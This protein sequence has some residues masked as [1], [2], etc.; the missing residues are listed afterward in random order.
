MTSTALTA[1]RPR[2]RRCTSAVTTFA[3]ADDCAPASRS[4]RGGGRRPRSARR[5]W[6]ID[7]S[8]GSSRGRMPGPFCSTVT[9]IP[10]RV[11]RLRHLDRDRPAADHHDARRRASRSRRGSRWSGS[12]QSASPAICGSTGRLPVQRRTKRPSSTRLSSTVTW[13]GPG[14]P[15]VTDDDLE[16][17]LAVALGIVVG[18]R[19]LRPGR[20]GSAATPSAGRSRGS[21]APM[22]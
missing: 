9:A 4:R 13:S 7:T 20:R 11:K 16:P 17:H 3:P 15:G 21:A 1:H 18:R 22:P 2:R 5:S 19:D 10:S 14:D 12:R 6:R 8:D